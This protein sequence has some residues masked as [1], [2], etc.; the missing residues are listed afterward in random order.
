MKAI[1]TRHDATLDGGNVTLGNAAV[2]ARMLR[3][4]GY[5][6]PFW[7][8][9]ASGLI[10]RADRVPWQGMVEAGQ[11]EILSEEPGG[12]PS[13]VF[14]SD[15]STGTGTGD[16][17]LR[18]TNKAPLEWTSVKGTSTGTIIV[19]AASTGRTWPAGIVNVMQTWC[20][21]PSGV[22][23][24][25][26][27]DRFTALAPG[28]D[29]SWRWYISEETNGDDIG[30][31]FIHGFQ[32]GRQGGN[33]DRNWAMREYYNNDGTWRPEFYV[34]HDDEIEGGGAQVT[35]WVLANAP[36]Y[37]GNEIWLST[38]VVYG[39]EVR[40]YAIDSDS[41]RFEVRVY[42]VDGNLLYDS[43]KWF[44]KNDNGDTLADGPTFTPSTLNGVYSGT[45]DFQCGSNGWGA[46]PASAFVAS[47]IG[48][49]AIG[50]GG[51]IG[52]YSGGI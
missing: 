15:W 45:N 23:G 31:D 6:T 39:F 26:L 36:G 8:R 12:G 5:A 35:A 34:P 37:P 14:H 9:T 40:M 27:T 17:A 49:V 44:R 50:K 1:I 29:M 18:D 42:D 38:G 48:G 16:D 30:D 10:V 22:Q 52:P 51:W 3:V 2:R 20:E 21:N 41:M 25:R 11:A 32:D 28:E 24:T 13:I 19:T 43:D 4:S 7:L 46:D 47:Y 33:A